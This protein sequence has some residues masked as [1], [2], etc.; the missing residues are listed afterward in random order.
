MHLLKDMELFDAQ[1]VVPKI[2]MVVGARTAVGF[3]THLRALE[4]L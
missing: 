4:I 3:E 1:K 2:Q